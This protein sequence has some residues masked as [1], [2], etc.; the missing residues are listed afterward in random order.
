ME[1]GLNRS[2][3]GDVAHAARSPDADQAC[4]LHACNIKPYETSH[5]KIFGTLVATKL[6]TQL[7]PK[8]I[9]TLVVLQRLYKHKSMIMNNSI[10]LL[11]IY[12]LTYYF[13]G[14]LQSQLQYRK[15]NKHK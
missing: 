11:F 1:G 10:K 15:R 9:S 8:I 4:Q 5:R 14:Q 3:V 6:V 12:V 13:N 2:P 7:L